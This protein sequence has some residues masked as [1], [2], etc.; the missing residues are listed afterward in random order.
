M[1]KGDYVAALCEPEPISFGGGCALSSPQYWRVLTVCLFAGPP[2]TGMLRYTRHSEST[3][4]RSSARCP[5]FNSDPLLLLPS[6]A[7]ARGPPSATSHSSH[8]RGILAQR[9]TQNRGF[10]AKP[11]RNTTKC[12]AVRR[13]PS[14]TVAFDGCDET[15]TLIMIQTQLAASE[16]SSES[17]PV[18]L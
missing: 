18:L 1:G 5:T 9:Y 11:C 7:H 6:Y 3:K 13:T 2:F 4:D 8:S 12:D 17:P 10:Q 16:S 14:L 15:V